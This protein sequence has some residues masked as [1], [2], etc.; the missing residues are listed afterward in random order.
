MCYILTRILRLAELVYFKHSSSQQRL[1][2]GGI[3]TY[4][5]I[6]QV[7]YFPLFFKEFSIFFSALQYVAF[8]WGRYGI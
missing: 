7:A 3:C 8:Q 5:E 1:G 2:W 6:P 4:I